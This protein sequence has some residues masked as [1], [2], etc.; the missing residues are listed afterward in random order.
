MGSYLLVT[1]R[2]LVD[3]PKTTLPTAL[4]RDLK[5]LNIMFDSHK[6][7]LNLHT[8]A[9]DRGKSSSI[10]PFSFLFFNYVST[11]NESYII[12]IFFMMVIIKSTML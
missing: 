11:K 12:I 4:K 7:L 2:P 9:K 8:M 10:R 5:A 3:E 1:L 6:D